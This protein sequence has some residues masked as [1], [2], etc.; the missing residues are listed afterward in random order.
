MPTSVRW[1]PRLTRV[2]HGLR[3]R[4][5]ERRAI[6]RK[7]EPE[8][9]DASVFPADAVFE[10]GGVL[11]VAFL[12][13][14][15][16]CEEAGIRWRHLAGTSA[17]AITASFLAS[18]LSLDEI[19]GILG[20]LD[21]ADLLSEKTSRWIL[22]R[23]PSDDLRHAIRMFANL[24]LARRRGQY[25]TRPFYNWLSENLAKGGI[26]TF[27][28]LTVEGDGARLRSR[29]KVVVSDIT[30][31]QM[32]ILPD[33]L[34][35]DVRG[36]FPVAEAVRLSMSIP[37]FFEPGTLPAGMLRCDPRM[38][39]CDEG[40]VI[41]DGGILSNFPVWLFD[42][43]GGERP[44]W[45]TFGFRLVDPAKNIPVKVRGP[46]GVAFAMFETMRTAHDRH[47]S[48]RKKSR[49]IDI[50]LSEPI[51]RHR[52]SVTSFKLTALEKDA[53][54]KAGYESTKRFLLEEWDWREHLRT[55]GFLDGNPRNWL[56]QG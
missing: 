1:D 28:S 26:G 12:G 19:E 39:Y 38:S 14:A 4:E 24:L 42:A 21:F 3:L 9:G 43:E 46:S 36:A 22:D 48:A 20:D 6:Q 5:D 10:G 52:L 11:G 31:G 17:G 29:L 35:D 32:L 40:A 49:T 7:L 25:S 55:R 27:G 33:D 45:P 2:T 41:V 15:R 53:L 34:N 30:H 56:G 47:L 8:R 16:C 23:D 18:R 44:K 37:F 13:A 54:Y 50:D 51:H